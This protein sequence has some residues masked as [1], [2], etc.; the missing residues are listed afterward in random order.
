MLGVKTN[1]NMQFKGENI[2]ES[3]ERIKED[4]SCQAYFSAI[5]Q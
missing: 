2:I 4:M 5:K 3:S 1:N